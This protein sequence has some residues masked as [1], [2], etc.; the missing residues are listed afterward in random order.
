MRLEAEDLDEDDL[1]LIDENLGRPKK[2]GVVVS[3]HVSSYLR[4]SSF[5]TTRLPR[6]LKRKSK[7]SSKNWTPSSHSS[8]GIIALLT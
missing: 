4:V 3:L 8:R 5:I 1:Q 2:D 7:K 6:D